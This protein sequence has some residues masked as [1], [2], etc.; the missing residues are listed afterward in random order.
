[1]FDKSSY[2]ELE[3]KIQNVEQAVSGTRQTEVQSQTFFTNNT[4]YVFWVE[5]VSPIS[6]AP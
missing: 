2:K 1:M 5:T 3:R 4:S 6:I